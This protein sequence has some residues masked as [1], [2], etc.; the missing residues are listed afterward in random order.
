MANF[1]TYHSSYHC[2]GIA[3]IA[4]EYNAF[5]TKI[6]TPVA[7]TNRKSSTKPPTLITCSTQ[8]YIIIAMF[9]WCITYHLFNRNNS[10]HLCA[11]VLFGPMFIRRIID[12][13]N[14]SWRIRTFEDVTIQISFRV[15]WTSMAIK[16]V[17]A[18]DSISSKHLCASWIVIYQPEKI[19]M[20]FNYETNN[21]HS[22]INVRYSNHR[23]ANSDGISMNMTGF[24]SSV[25]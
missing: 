15:S 5:S 12:G 11:I 13:S 8:W 24:S 1:S 19:C 21:F 14:S 3:R 2:C 6:W 9:Y 16:E 18:F 7:K 10:F 25:I 17:L 22:S 20:L 4:F 23:V